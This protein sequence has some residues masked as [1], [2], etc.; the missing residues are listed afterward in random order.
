MDTPENNQN[1]LKVTY[2]LPKPLAKNNEVNEGAKDVVM[3]PKSG[4]ETSHENTPVHGA[5]STGAA[6][7]GGQQ[8]VVSDS[9]QTTVT[10][11]ATKQDD[12]VPDIADDVDLIEK[13]WVEKAKM[14]V[15][16][17]KDDPYEQNKEIS[18]FKAAYI[19][20]RYNKEV[21]AQKE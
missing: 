21:R 9:A 8:T 7:A 2:N 11:T 16:K 15:D 12:G 3:Q 5:L 10:S 17:T 19:K 13:E 1:Q 4:T 14:I 18:N 6:P 20:K